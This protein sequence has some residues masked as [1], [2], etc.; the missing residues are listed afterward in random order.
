MFSR[1]F[2]AEKRE[3]AYPSKLTFEE[4]LEVFATLDGGV[5]RFE[6]SGRLRLF[7]F[8]VGGAD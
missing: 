2:S 4:A 8:V 6:V 3:S 7:V 5:P 1:F